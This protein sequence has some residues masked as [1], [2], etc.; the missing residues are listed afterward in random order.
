MSRLSLFP[1]LLCVALIAGCGSSRQA[2]HE[3]PAP[4]DAK[5]TVR[6]DNA[7]FLDMT[8][9]VLDGSQRVRLGI[10]NGHAVTKLTIPPHLVRGV[11][12]LRFLADPIGG[13]R[14]PVSDQIVVEPGDQVTL[15][16]PAD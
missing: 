16:I 10:A 1:L 11:S 6:V 7:G 8:V 13:N 3:T 4:L 15:F 5:T 12:T 2:G 9:Y 14:A